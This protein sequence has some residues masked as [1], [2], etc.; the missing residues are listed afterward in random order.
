MFDDLADIIPAISPKEWN[1]IDVR[2]LLDVGNKLFY[3]IHN[4]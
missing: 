2:L 1:I 3:N 4:I